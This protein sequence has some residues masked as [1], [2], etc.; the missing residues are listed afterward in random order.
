MA[1]LSVESLPAFS[2]NLSKDILFVQQLFVDITS[3]TQTQTPIPYQTMLHRALVSILALSISI[4]HTRVS[5]FGFS[6]HTSLTKVTKKNHQRLVEVVTHQPTYTSPS[7]PHDKL[8]GGTAMAESKS[9]AAP[10]PKK[11]IRLTALD[12]IRA[13]LAL[14]IVLGHFL[15]FAKPNDILLRFFAQVNI[16]VGAFFAISGY[17]TAYTSTE[18]GER[19]AS[20]RLT[21]TPS[22]KWWLQKVMAFYP[23]HWLVLALFS[24]MFIFSD[25][26]YGGWIDA[27]INGLMSFTLTQAWFP[28]HGEVW[29]APTWFLSSLVFSTSIL[30]FALP[31]IAKMD[32]RGLR[33]TTGWLW[34]IKLLPVLGYIHD[35]NIW[36]VEGMTP[37]KYHPALA[38][39]NTQRFHP[40]FNV[41]EILMGATVCRLAMLDDDKDNKA[42]KTNWL[43]TAAPLAGCIGILAARALGWVPDCS[44]LLVRSLVFTPLFLKFVLGS[45]RNT[46]AGASDPVSNFL[47]KK[48]LVWLG[49]LSFPIFV[50][51]G[52]LGQV[53]YKKLI[54]NKLW[55]GVLWGPKY[56]AMYLASVF[57]SAILLQNLFLANKSV[58]AWSKKKAQEL[59]EWM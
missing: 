17:V 56:F 5:A 44:D 12:G 10:A 30:P 58:G 22:Q 36:L 20:A 1:S 32:K 47:S 19:K 31:K 34:L 54:A 57:C 41:A 18:V 2:Y 40:V 21:E 45:H 14:H 27:A 11:R 39:F 7:Y 37:P 8:R 49:G 55:G 28:M 43:S 9:S 3:T 53:F 35:H 23:M 33:K 16:T 38:V 6:E 46:V 24:P 4:D 42:P 50:V 52:P 26:T 29:N 59:S 15:R 51:H 13:L 25:I 48:T